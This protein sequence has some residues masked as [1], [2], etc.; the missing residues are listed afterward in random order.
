MA[1]P[2]NPTLEARLA[3]LEQ[4][5]QELRNRLAALERTLASPGEHPVDQSAVRRKVTYDWQS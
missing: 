2:S 4:Q 5:L 1:A 3:N